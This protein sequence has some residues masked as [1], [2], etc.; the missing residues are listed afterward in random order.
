MQQVLDRLGTQLKGHKYGFLKVKPLFGETTREATYRLFSDH[1]ALKR[2]EADLPN[3]DILTIAEEESLS[4]GMTQDSPEVT[5][6]KEVLE[7][8]LNDMKTQWGDSRRL[9]EGTSLEYTQ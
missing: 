2:S 7:W 6:A 5:M 1:E 3:I 8:L 9:V 4:S